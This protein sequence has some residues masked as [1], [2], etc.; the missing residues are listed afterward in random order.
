MGE[1]HF[2]T[3]CLGLK[4]PCGI[5]DRAGKDKITWEVI[6]LKVP[7]TGVYR[8]VLTEFVSERRSYRWSI[9]QGIVS[10]RLKSGKSA[11]DRVIKN[12]HFKE[13]APYDVVAETFRAAG[14]SM[15]ASE[16]GPRYRGPMI[17]IER[18]SAS[19][20]EILNEIVR[21]DGQATWTATQHG[22]KYAVVFQTWG[23]NSLFR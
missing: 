7:V 10:I 14:I 18:K 4:I 16:D 12:V 22:D 21:A 9:E 5:E 6:P 17:S 2:P 11:L 8:D 3:F 1:I 23:E 13:K 19:V 20:R 15:S